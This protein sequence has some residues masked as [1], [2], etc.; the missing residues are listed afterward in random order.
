VIEKPAHWAI[1]AIVRAGSIGIRARLN[2]RPP[3]RQTFAARQQL[4]FLSEFFR[5]ALP[6]LFAQTS[7]ALPVRI[8]R[9]ATRRIVR[10]TRAGIARMLCFASP[11]PG[12]WRAPEHRIMNFFF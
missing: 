1:R 4:R 12:V 9:R 2:D 5:L 6:R 3:L 11:D 8:E 10:R 7:P